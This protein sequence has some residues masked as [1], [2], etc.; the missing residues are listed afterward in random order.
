MILHIASWYP[1]PWDSI[2]GNFVRDQ[3]AVFREELPAEVVVVQVRPN[4]GRG[5]RLARLELEGGARGYILYAPVRPGSKP[6]E[7]LSTLLLLFV[8]LREAAWRFEAFHFHI[9]Y[10]LLMQVHLWRWLF[11]KPIVISEHWSAYHF[12][13]HLP[14]GSRA[15]KRM[16]RPFRQGY[17]VLAVSAALLDDIRRFARRDDFKGFVVPNVVPL[18]GADTGQREQPEFFTVNRWVS[19]KN[20]M[21]MLEGLH[22]AAEAGQAFTLVLGGYGDLIE[23]MTDFVDHSALRERTRFAG[24]MTKPEIAEQLAASDGYLFSSDYETFSIACAEAL[25]AGVPL[26]GP[27]IPAIAEYAGPGDRVEVR[28]RT[29]EAWQEAITAFVDTWAGGGWDRTAIARRA[30]RRFFQAQLRANYRA[31]MSSLGLG[32]VRVE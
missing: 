23:E 16:R 20:P 3:I 11:R 17:A 2:E 1:G 10:P 7:W 29:P 32:L 13:F 21:P 25:G 9:A 18:H 4:A 27:C 28:S 19:V 6:L 30:A 5:L 24:K 31:A 22:R 15:L 26:V 8:L 14:E 12:N